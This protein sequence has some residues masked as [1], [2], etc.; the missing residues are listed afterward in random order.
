SLPPELLRKG[1]LDEIFFVDLPG[2][3]ER[4]RI[5]GI[6]LAKRGRSLPVSTLDELSLACDGFSGAEI[7]QAV[8]SALYDAFYSG[9]E[10]TAASLDKAFRESVPLSRTM[11][12]RI[13][14]LRR[15]ADGRARRASLQDKSAADAT[16]P[17]GSRKLEA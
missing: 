8:V 2:P 14:G 13:A 7:E 3:R 9:G 6:H 16:A 15:W 1:R 10:L 12:E 11:S 17:L 4:A 5:L